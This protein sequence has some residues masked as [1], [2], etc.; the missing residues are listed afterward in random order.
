MSI[1][2]GFGVV[3]GQG[4]AVREVGRGYGEQVQTV[5]ISINEV[6]ELHMEVFSIGNSINFVNR[7]TYKECYY[8][9]FVVQL[10]IYIYIHICI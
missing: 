4:Q 7:G 3:G 10:I 2:P 5:F 1:Q 9:S 6:L 8:G